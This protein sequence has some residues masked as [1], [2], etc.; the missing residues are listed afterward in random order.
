MQNDKSECKIFKEFNSQLLKL[1]KIGTLNF[2]KLENKKEEVIYFDVG[3]TKIEIGII[4]ADKGKAKIKN[5]KNINHRNFSGKAVLRKMVTFINNHKDLPVRISFAGQVDCQ[6]NKI[7]DYSNLK[8]FERV[9]FLEILKSKCK[10]VLIYNDAVCSA[11]GIFK[12]LRGINNLVLFIIGTGLGGAVIKKERKKFVLYSSEPGRIACRGKYWEDF[13]AGKFIEKRFKKLSGKSLTGEGI[14]ILFEKGNKAA[15]RVYQE[16]A[17]NLAQSILPYLKVLK[18][19]KKL[20]KTAIVLYG[21]VG[22]NVKEYKNFVKKYLKSNVCSGRLP[23]S[24]GG[25]AQA[26][27]RRIKIYRSK[28]II[29][30]INPAAIGALEIPI[31]LK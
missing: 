13:I 10:D 15:K 14:N 23:V 7:I 21:G 24:V 27:S 18:L 5:K 16:S 3:G 1:Q 25:S 4:L 17:Q 28:E 26:G 20:S 29:R 6:K 2:K 22:D 30:D 19:D 8:K 31:I 12:K 9:N 11:V